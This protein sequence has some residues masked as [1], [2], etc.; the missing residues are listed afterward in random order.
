M[1][2]EKGKDFRQRGNHDQSQMA[3]RSIWMPE[4]MCKK[5]T[6]KRV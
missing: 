5:Q 4:G 1:A 6:K 2:R 3:G